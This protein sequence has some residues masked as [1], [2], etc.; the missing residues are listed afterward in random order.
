M[1][2]KTEIITTAEQLRSGAYFEDALKWYDTK[3]HAPII[4]K[5]YFVVITFLAIIGTI[6]SI[7]AFLS[8]LP[9]QSHVNFAVKEKYFSEKNISLVPLSDTPEGTDIGLLNFLVTDYIERRE[10]YGVSSLDSNIRRV[11]ALSS[12]EIFTSYSNALRASNPQS[13]INTLGN[14]GRI[15][16]QVN[17][18]QWQFSTGKRFDDGN[19]PQSAEITFTTITSNG[20]SQQEQQGKAL[21]TFDYTPVQIN[22]ETL[23]IIPMSFTVLQY[24]AVK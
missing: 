13:P 19:L 12:A 3:Y 15:D 14:R 23:E 2:N 1:D 4:E 18:I 20:K 17:R 6:F 24:N 10:S 8:L 16:T 9:I 22:Q 5:A 11:R 21:I 7:A